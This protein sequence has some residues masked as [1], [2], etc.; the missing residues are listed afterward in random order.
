[1]PA[2]CGAI[3]F[4]VSPAFR[5]SPD[6]SSSAA[7]AQ[8]Q[9]AR[10]LRSAVAECQEA[11]LPWTEVGERIGL[12]RETVFRQWAS[13]GPIVTV[14]ASPARNTVVSDNDRPS[15]VDAVFVFQS[16]QPGGQAV[17]RT[18]LRVRVG[19]CDQNVSFNSVQA[20]LADGTERRVTHEVTNLLYEDGET[21]L[22][23][24]LTQ[25]VRATLSNPEVAETFAHTVHR[26]ATAQARRVPA[27]GEVAGD[28][29]VL[30]VV[31]Q[32]HGERPPRP[33]PPP[34]PG[35]VPPC[36]SWNRRTQRCAHWR[37]T[38]NSRATGATGLPAATRWTA[39]GGR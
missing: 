36:P 23:R 33:G 19:H 15:A 31:G 32:A 29:V 34:R 7:E 30:G 8:S 12:P 3:A 28:P 35:C 24:A 17:C 38:P 18:L 16:G 14:R 25:F 27:G 6:R 1:M 26:A 4:C 20:Q 10:A 21:P 13:D 37:D 5:V 11:D 2:S 39:P 22:R 9:L